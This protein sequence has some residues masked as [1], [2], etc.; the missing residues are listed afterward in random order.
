MEIQAMV[1]AHKLLATISYQSLARVGNVELLSPLLLVE[2]HKVVWFQWR[3][4]GS[5]ASRICSIETQ[6]QM[7][8]KPNLFAA[9]LIPRRET[10]SVVAK[11]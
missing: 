7:L 11:Q 3:M 2:H 10:P 9:S 8:C 6:P 4:Q 5:G 1:F